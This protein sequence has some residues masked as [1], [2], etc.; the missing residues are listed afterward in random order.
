MTATERNS[1][2]WVLLVIVFLIMLAVALA[3]CTREM[4]AAF[5]ADPAGGLEIPVMTFGVIG[6]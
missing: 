1:G 3:G 4:P 5:T 2:L 6:F